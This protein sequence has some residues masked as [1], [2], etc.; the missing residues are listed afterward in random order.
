MNNLSKVLLIEDD[1]FSA[2]LVH[3]ILDQGCD[4][5]HAVDGRE[6]LEIIEHTPPDLVLLDVELPG[7]SGL[8]LCRTIRANPATQDMPVIFI[9]GKATDQDKMAGY[10]AGG[11]DYL[12]KPVAAVDLRAK[13]KHALRL[14]A[15]RARIRQNLSAAVSTAMSAV[16]G[17]EEIGTLMNF[18]RRS[19]GCPDYASL[20][21]DALSVTGAYGLTASIQ[22]RG[23]C[24]K[25]SGSWAGACSPLEEEVL[26]SIATQGHNI[27][28]SHY[29][30]FSSARVSIIVRNMPEAT[31]RCGRIKNHLDFLL[32]AVDARVAA[33]DHA[34]NISEIGRLAASADKAL[35][36]INQVLNQTDEERRLIQEALCVKLEAAFVMLGLT[37]SQEDEVSR[38]AQ[39]VINEALTRCDG[40]MGEGR[41]VAA[42]LAR[43]RR[44]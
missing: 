22:L 3:D 6:A 27:D 9:S 30:A 16:S 14:N 24:G 20:V 7:M 38:L 10:E 33:L 41:A 23:D 25:A 44:L 35:E 28:F 34:K 1:D 39:L 40:G 18:V 8:E 5:F 12:T 32:D 4:K 21:K 11:D 13:V 36:H 37:Q 42:L 17:T 29:T 31:D 2:A 19:F 26:T 43:L 15:D